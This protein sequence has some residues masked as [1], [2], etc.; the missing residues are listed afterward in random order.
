MLGCQTVHKLQFVANISVHK[1]RS[2][3]ALPMMVV[4]TIEVKRDADILQCDGLLGVVIAVVVVESVRL[5]NLN[6]PVGSL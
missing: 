4:A 2:R 3:K 6:V 1:A 5:A